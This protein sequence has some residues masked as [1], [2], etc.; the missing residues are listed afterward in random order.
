[1]ISDSIA[2]TESQSYGHR[3]MGTVH[4]TLRPFFN[5]LRGRHVHVPIVPG[6]SNRLRSM[7]FPE[8]YRHLAYLQIGIGYSVRPDMP[9]VTGPGVESLY[10]KGAQ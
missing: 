9:G 2:V 10:V 6:Q 5:M 4:L 3:V 1:M 7:S 8:G